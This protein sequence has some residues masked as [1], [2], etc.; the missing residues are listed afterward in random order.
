MEGRI[1]DFQKEGAQKILCPQ[2]TSRA[3]SPLESG[4]LRVLDDI[5]RYLSLIL[6]HSD[7][8]LDLKNKVDQ[9]LE[10]ACACYTSTWI[11]RCHVMILTL[12]RLGGGGPR[13]PPDISRDNSGTRKALA[14]TLYDNFLSSFLHILTP[15][16]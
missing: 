8:K 3:R 15:N 14:T 1:Q 10:G 13:C 9:N 2:R 16:L 11:R 12:I 5:S 4:S 7:T 6:K